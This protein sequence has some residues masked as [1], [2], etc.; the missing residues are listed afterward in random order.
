MTTGLA[1]ELVEVFIQ[2]NSQGGCLHV[3]HG[4]TIYLFCQDFL[5]PNMSNQRGVV[6]FFLCCS[7]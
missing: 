4:K 7:F 6:T 3:L 1:E 5:R 2:A